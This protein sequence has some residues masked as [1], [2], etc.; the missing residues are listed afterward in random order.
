[1]NTHDPIRL[2]RR[3]ALGVGVAIAAAA[4]GIPDA[5][6]AHTPNKA[7]AG[8]VLN[9][10]FNADGTGT[11]HPTGW[12]VTG[13]AAASFTEATQYGFAGDGFQLTHWSA[14]PYTVD[15]W[16]RISGLPNGTYTLSVWVK[17]GGGDTA[18][19]IELESGPRTSRTS[20]PVIATG[21]WLNV[22]TSVHVTGHEATIHL[23][24]DSAAGNWTN[25]GLVA[26]TP[27]DTAL[28]IRGADLSSLVRGEALGGV[29][30]DMQGRQRSAWDIL[31]AAGMNY[32]RLRVWVHP[33]DGF[34]D[35]QQLL[36]GARQAKRR[37]QK[38]LL[39]FHYSDTWTDPGHQA[40]PAAWAN[41]TLPQL[42]QAVH[43]YSADVVSALVRQGTPPDMVQIGNEING[44]LLW[45]L[46]M[47]YGS[48]TAFADFAS[49]LEAG[50]A[51]VKS[52][53][54]RAQIAL[55]IANAA[56]WGGVQWFYDNVQAQNVPFDLIGLS[57]Y[58]YWHGYLDELQTTLNNTAARYRKPIFLAETAY[59]WTLQSGD[60]TAS[61]SF[62]DS[63]ELE[64]GYPATPAGQAAMFR[65]TLSIVQA[66]PD[67]LGFGAFYWEPAW[68][69]VK[70][71]GWD[72]TNPS[73]GDGWENQA[74]FDYSDH[75]L[76]A[77]TVYNPR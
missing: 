11:A 68:T 24:S 55:H 6:Q 22:V 73:A 12:N 27:G 7:G 75:A 26:L 2:S 54:P 17:S 74:M 5:A 51:G 1:M 71:N 19:Y 23:V 50:I 20:V 67:G 3:S 16:Q 46:G 21:S 72:P 30:Y 13:D 45:P 41:F 10:A 38:L 60:P 58:S 44:G 40:T 56:N 59:P 70:G 57:Y 53:A 33:E 37:G 76:P 14:A 61:L 47:N 28:P 63:S 69:V 34:D 49:L 64:T 39:D 48:A 66:V 9:P 8:T 15:T 32:V 29:Y 18:N 62:S 42:Q 43:D 52:A 4:I 77:L 31:E 25:Y 36:D 35:E 65:D